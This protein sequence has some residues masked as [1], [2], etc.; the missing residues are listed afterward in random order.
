MNI[1]LKLTEDYG[2]QKEASRAIDI[3]TSTFSDWITGKKI[4]NKTNIQMLINYGFSIGD[5][6]ETCF[7]PA[8]KSVP[9]SL[10]NNH[11]TRL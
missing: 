2:S 8:K 7:S 3:P 10:E 11:G 5:I 4:P 6:T 1:F 9:T